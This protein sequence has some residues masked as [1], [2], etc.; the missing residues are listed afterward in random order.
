MKP[1]DLLKPRRWNVTCKVPITYLDVW[2]RPD[3]SDDWQGKWEHDQIGLLLPGR[4]V[5]GDPDRDPTSCTMLEVLLNDRV[6]WVLEDE[7]EVVR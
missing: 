3:G 2:N 1:G 5:S 6:C 7:V 4:Y